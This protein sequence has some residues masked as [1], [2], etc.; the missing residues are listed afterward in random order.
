[1]KLYYFGK[2]KFYGYELIAKTKQSFSSCYFLW[3]ERGGIVKK[4]IDPGAMHFI[5]WSKNVTVFHYYLDRVMQCWKN[6]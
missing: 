4:K 6:I 2:I 3:F 1:M 5:Y